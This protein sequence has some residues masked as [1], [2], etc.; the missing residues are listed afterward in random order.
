MVMARLPL[1]VSS[2]LADI[3]I[4][5]E[6]LGIGRTFDVTDPVDVARTLDEMLEPETYADL[7]R[8]VMAAAEELCWEKESRAYVALF[9]REAEPARPRRDSAAAVR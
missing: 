2:E 8:N 7:R 5:M 1:A 6:K 9:T 4:L 3:R